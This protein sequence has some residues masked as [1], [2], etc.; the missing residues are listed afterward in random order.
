[1]VIRIL[2]EKHRQE[3][4][5]SE[6]EIFML[7]RYEQ[8]DSFRQVDKQN[9]DIFCLEKP[10]FH[11]LHWYP[12][13][14]HS[15]ACTY[16]RNSIFFWS[17]KVVSYVSACTKLFGCKCMH[18]YTKHLYVNLSSNFEISK[19]KTDTQALYDNS[20]RCITQWDYLKTIS[21]VLK[22]NWAIN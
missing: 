19:V 9:K 17:D 21:I 15:G 4:P 1:M 22:T 6:L 10:Y 3:I 13:I 20:K 14:P 8:S 12:I 16:V 2:F 18:K 5:T 7:I 11:L